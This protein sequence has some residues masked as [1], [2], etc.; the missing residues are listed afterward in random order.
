MAKAKAKTSVDTAAI[1]K[2]IVEAMV[3]IE[4]D[5]P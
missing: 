3:V 4:R 1:G 2:L 5:N